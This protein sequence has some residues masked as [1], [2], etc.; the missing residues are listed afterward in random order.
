MNDYVRPPKPRLA[1][2]LI[3]LLVVIAIIA[4]LAAILFP[5]FAKAREKARQATCASNLKQIG[6]A[7]TQYSQDND[8]QFSGA[9]TNTHNG[10]GGCGGDRILW[11]E[12]LYPYTKSAAVYTCPDNAPGENLQQSCGNSLGD[13]YNK[14]VGGQ[15]TAQSISPGPKNV[16]P[17]VSYGYNSII[18][19]GGDAPDCPGTGGCITDGDGGHPNL[20]SVDAPAETILILDEKQADQKGWEVNT[21]HTKNTD[22]KGSFYGDNWQGNPAI[23]H[24]H[25]AQWDDYVSCGKQHTDGSNILWYDGHVKWARNT[26]KVT[27]NAPQG[28]PY[29]WYLRK[30]VNP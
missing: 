19:D 17:G 22:V 18:N 4:I 8:E 30:P 21:W 29:Y 9:F 27:P 26:L 3:E 7:E 25:P 23:D 2:T 20:S 16:G 13:L 28:G 5:V 12:L 11:P 6:L 14:D 15:A 1:F 10:N 24:G